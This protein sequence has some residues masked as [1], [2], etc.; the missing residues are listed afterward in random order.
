MDGNPR[1]RGGVFPVYAAVTGTSLRLDERWAAL[2][3]GLFAQAGIS[4]ILS[5]ILSVPLAWLFELGGDTIWPPA[6]VHFVLQGAIKLILTEGDGG[7]MLPLV[8]MAASASLPFAA[9]FV[10]KH[11]TGRA[12]EP[13]T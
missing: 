6:I 2:V 9:V 5:A 4:V 7:A 10:P 11:S 8:W 1:R 3:P 13:S 12:S